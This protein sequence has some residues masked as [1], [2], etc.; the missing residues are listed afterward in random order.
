MKL[1]ISHGREGGLE[2][3]RR[4]IGRYKGEGRGE[5]R[6]KGLPLFGRWKI[7][8]SPIGSSSLTH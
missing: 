8:A 2:G 6:G 3:E 7:I 5:G 1:R 4:T